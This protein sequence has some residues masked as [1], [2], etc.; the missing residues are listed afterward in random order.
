MGFILEVAF[1]GI[2]LKLARDDWE[3]ME[4][5][6]EPCVIEW[7]ILCV[8][9]IV[10]GPRVSVL[11]AL[12]F[13]MALFYSEFELPYFGDADLL[14]VAGYIVYNGFPWENAGDWVLT[15]SVLLLVLMI[16]VVLY[17]K[18]NGNKNLL[19]LRI[20]MPALP[21]LSIALCYNFVISLI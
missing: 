16:S 19:D 11:C 4:V 14:P 21:A 1:L 20:E 3:Y 15:S 9:Y 10:N 12:A 7:M 5:A 8:S 2:L 6:G 17:N 18:K 13:C